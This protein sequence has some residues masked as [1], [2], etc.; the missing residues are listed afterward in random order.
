M[1]LLFKDDEHH[2]TSLINQEKTM[3]RVDVSKL[4]DQIEIDQVAE[5]LGM[6][7][8]NDSDTRKMA[9]CPFHNDTKPSLLIDTSRGHDFQHFHC[10]ACGEHGTAIDL[11]KE[12]L[13]VDFNNA[14]DWLCTTFGISARGPN[15]HSISADSKRTALERGYQ[16][17]RSESKSVLF[18]QWADSRQFK[19]GFLNNAGFAYSSSG[20]LTSKETFSNIPTKSRIEI[21]GDLED[22]GLVKK[23]LPTIGSSLHMHTGSEVQFADT[24]NGDRV[25][26]PIY[27][28]QR[29]LRGLAARA[30]GPYAS[31]Q[32]AKYLFTKNFPKGQILYR[33]DEAFK[34]IQASAK[35]GASAINLYLCE[36]FFDALRIESN[37]QAAVA[38]MGSTISKD[39]TQLLKELSENLPN[40]AATLTVV[41]CFDRDE[42]GLKGASTSALM[43]LDAGLDVA[44]LWPT[45]TSLSAFGINIESKD[46]DEYLKNLSKPEVLDL[47]TESMLP[48]GMAILAN[49]F[50]VSGE[51]LLN[52]INWRAASN[53]R[54]FRAF[55]KALADFRKIRIFN[56]ERLLEWISEPS[57]NKNPV[58]VEWLEYL[59][60]R[61]LNNSA[62]QETFLT[63]TVA[64]LNHARLLAYRGSRRGELACD[65]PMWE[66][67]DIGATSFNIVLSEHISRQSNQPVEAFDAVWIPRSFGGAEPRLKVMP[68]PEDLIVHQYLMNDLLTERWDLESIGTAQFSQY[69]PAVRFYRED[70]KTITTGLLE[71]AQGFEGIVR[72]GSPLSFAYQIDM[73]VVE[74]R[75]PASDQGMFRP[76]HECWHDFMQSL[77]LQAHKIGHVHVISLDVSRYYDRIR[78]SVMRDALQGKIQNAFESLPSDSAFLTSSLT[79]DSSTP[80]TNAASIVD[81]LADLIFEYPYKCPETGM[82]KNAEYARGI[83][84]GPVISAW[85]GTITLF[86]VDQVAAEIM[87]KHNSD[88]VVRV[89]YARYVDDIVLLAESASLLEELREAVDLKTRSLDLTL[90]A[91]ADEI[92]PM[93]SEE[94]STYINEGR[95]LD[96][97]GPTWSP[98][99]VGDG[100]Y[101]WDFWSAT[102]SSDR[103]SALQLLSNLDLYKSSQRIIVNTVRT[104]FL[105][106]DLRA[107]ELSKGARLLWYATAIDLV[108]NGSPS[109][110]STFNIWEKFN[111]Y[112]RECTEATG[113]Q[114]NPSQNGWESTTLFALEGLEK[115]IDHTSSQLRG[116]SLEED[117]IRQMR[118]LS[119]AKVVASKEFKKIIFSEEPKLVRQTN[120]RFELLQWK[121]AK[122]TGI[123]DTE[124]NENVERSR[125]VETWRPFDWL[126]S[127]IE[128]LTNPKGENNTDPMI[129]FEAPYLR[130]KA[131][132]T[133]Y[134]KSFELFGYF[135]PDTALNR[136]ELTIEAR[137]EFENARLITCSLQT[138]ASIAPKE[139]IYSLLMAR[140][141]LLNIEDTQKLIFMPPLPGIEQ[142]RLLACH[143]HEI[144]SENPIITEL[145]T[146]EFRNNSNQTQP[147]NFIGVNGDLCIELK[148]NWIIKSSDRDIIVQSSAVI[149]HES[150]LTIKVRPQIIATKDSHISLREAAQL[151][152]NIVL[153]ILEFS[154]QHP[155]YE[156]IPA[157]P[158]IAKDETTKSMF[159][160]CEGAKNDEIGNRA[161]IKD[162]GRALRTVEVPIFEAHLWRAGMALSDYLGFNDDITRFKSSSSEIPFD[163]TASKSMAIFVLRTQCR[164]LRGAFADSQIARR[165]RENSS[166]PASIDRALE[167]LEQFPEDG[168]TKS[169]LKFVLATELET[170]AMR[171]RLQRQE[172]TSA[173]CSFLIST[174]STVL[175]QLPISI[176]GMLA[177]EDRGSTGLRRDFEGVL[178]LAR[179]IWQFP[180]EEN[181]KDP[182]AWHA[183]RSGV[184]GLG[185]KV[186][187]NGMLASL[188]SHPEFSSYASFDFPVEWEIPA[189]QIFDDQDRGLKNSTAT[190]ESQG[191]QQISLIDTL[192]NLVKLLA[193][194]LRATSELN[195]HLNENCVNQIKSLAIHL[196]TIE[197]GDHD[198]DSKSAWP[199]EGISKSRISNLNIEL[200]ESVANLLLEL[201]KE[202]SLQVL[203]V[204]EETYGYNA[205]TRRFT[206]SRNRTWE[207]K[208]SM[209]S[210]FPLRAKN[211]EEQHFN[212]QI[213]KVWTEVIEKKSGRLL[214]VAVL[215]DQFASIAILK[216]KTPA[217]NSDSKITEPQNENDSHQVVQIGPDFDQ[218]HRHSFA[219]ARSNSVESHATEDDPS[220]KDKNGIQQPHS[221]KDS[222]QDNRNVSANSNR[223]HEFRLRQQDEWSKKKDNK[224]QAHLRVAILQ[225]C[226]DL[227]YAHPM[228]EV[229]PKNWPFGEST[230]SL[231][232]SVLTAHKSPIYDDLAKAVSKPG[233]GYLWDKE[234]ISLP[235][236]AEHRRRRFLE[237]TINTCEDFGVDLLVLPE[238]SIRPETVNWLRSFL[239]GKHVAI[240][241]GTFMEFSNKV[242]QSRGSAIMN[243]LWPIPNEILHG[244][245]DINTGKKFEVTPSNSVLQLTRK[246]KYRSVGLN[247]FIRPGTLPLAPLF[248]PAD[249]VDEIK[250]Q[251]QTSLSS[252]GIVRLLASIRLPLQHFIELIC[253][254]IFL[255]TS[256]ANYPQIAKDYTWA[257]RRFGQSA[258]KE[259]VFSDV[260]KLATHLAI[261]AYDGGSPRRSIAV[262][263]AAT[264][265]TADY[266][267][268]GQAAL[269]AAGTTTVFCNATGH[270][271]KGGSCFI[272]RESWKGVEDVIGYIPSITPY[273]GWSKGIYYNSKNDPL[274]ETDQAI[275][276]ADI[277]PIHMNEGKPRPQ[278]LPVPLQLVAYLPIAETVDTSTL[279]KKLLKLLGASKESVNASVQQDDL[280]K[281]LH[282]AKEFW[283]SV[284]KFETRYDKEMIKTFSKFFS[285]P[286]AIVE[287]LNA[288]KNDA[289]QQPCFLSIDTSTTNSPAFYDWLDIDLTLRD[290]ETLPEISVPP[291]K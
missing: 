112:W 122:T 54:K 222:K 259:D 67:L 166:L 91:K 15:S 215:G 219:D 58:T 155:G 4:L 104:A 205:K 192:R 290:G 113:W 48:P 16:I 82:V 172:L 234:N 18:V 162:G 224:N 196:A 44:F 189:A 75:Q 282:D 185:I 245:I 39:Q 283:D 101:G 258:G 26:I 164:K 124:Q 121:I 243:L 135:L 171:A 84:Q 241:A 159:L 141:R 88:G 3:S 253:S 92:P 250:K 214:S 216:S 137:S 11:V 78:R 175:S 217:S 158:Y 187:L 286:K 126:H 23:L 167:L 1:I 120:R 60:N 270:E 168:D 55:E 176:G 232:P 145:S 195:D 254:E 235:S 22:A 46:P 52:E 144:G 42:A 45:A 273:H 289:S 206:D 133:N 218:A 186:G 211:I 94:F 31:T 285:D 150:S 179:T 223:A 276:I 9:I 119:L 118:I 169:Q 38:V 261:G 199:F 131:T 191:F 154:N 29:K 43:L 13:S 251:H 64:R 246:K 143:I 252:A 138:L 117:N 277:D 279:N 47:I 149:P 50:G 115:L 182:F 255:L 230:K 139:R 57:N 116:L 49:R 125:P 71:R 201:D 210:Q 238:Y 107:T 260:E 73:D 197:Y 180:F 99:I 40:K 76:Y 32:K 212:G 152:R 226:T 151:Y 30:V 269:L 74:G 263:P 249:L 83:P 291:W 242:P 236:W 56:S 77:K 265:R 35:E 61:L 62:I 98:P 79:S 72:E 81:Q 127:A 106:M 275:V 105:A 209:I 66:R 267:I 28:L 262:I 281:Q 111:S 51:D 27:D 148:P 268:A 140:R 109:S 100:E 173:P 17:Y 134:L 220:A 272:G 202:L 102:P 89:G 229:S 240:L 103:Q 188:S 5:K 33:A 237:R 227:T 69:I 174:V 257:N 157:W 184:V 136:S 6:R 165:V 59:N 207:T 142:K 97:S 63:N 256:P 108:E 244:S 41:I 85:I 7:L 12:R 80:A 132:I 8:Q 147:F 221:P 213:L 177:S 248:S 128:L 193:H 204:S 21:L 198:D 34:S 161:F 146:F 24:F 19:S 163:E 153:A 36:G 271:L 90:I 70:K 20:T 190:K 287:R 233:N 247:E 278:L 288:A 228:C 25:I 181:E 96:G 129:V 274:S 65:E 200:L 2:L 114:L 183:F 208:P 160:L 110:I 225:S 37:G 194:R 280:P 156:L 86:S 14:V 123:Q 239:S 68:R 87:A 266:W 284:A 203:Y 170:A 130:Q 53:S 264:T 10:F 93:T 178:S 95:M 231:L